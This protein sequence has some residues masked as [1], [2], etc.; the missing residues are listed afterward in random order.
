MISGL[1]GDGLVPLGAKRKEN[2]R[3]LVSSVSG[4]WANSGVL[5]EVGQLGRFQPQF[6][7]LV[8]P[9]LRSLHLFP[10]ET[11]GWVHWFS[12]SKN[13]PLWVILMPCSVTGCVEW[14]HCPC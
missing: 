5:Y 9:Y 10:D 3:A 1:Y 11:P 6:F 2:S 4:A 13:L 12:D 7:G 8:E 14:E